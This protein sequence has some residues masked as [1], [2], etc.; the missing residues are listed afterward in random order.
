MRN[1][2]QPED[3]GACRTCGTFISED[4]AECYPCGHQ[5][6]HLD[7]VVPITYS[8][9]LG[10]MHKA[11]WGYKNGQPIERNYA[12]PRLTAILWRFL[13]RH[14]ACVAKAAGAGNEEFDVITT[15][16]S[17]AKARDKRNR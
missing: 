17:S 14:E 1:V 13:Q 7:V 15:V 4:F 5:Q 6:D 9:H 16:P 3:D 12:G 2:L 8:E 10:Q 11:L